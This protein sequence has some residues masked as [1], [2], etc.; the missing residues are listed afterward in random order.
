MM[1]DGLKPC[2]FC[3]CPLNLMPD[4]SL[5]AWHDEEC[6]FSLMDEH[7]VDMEQEEIDALF[8]KA[9]NRRAEEA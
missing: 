7:E 1:H 5:W 8:I 6:F 4:G 3:G 2:P 9:W